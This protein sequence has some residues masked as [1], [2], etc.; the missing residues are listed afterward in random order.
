MLGLEFITSDIDLTSVLKAD[1][2]Y[3]T[4]GVSFFVAWVGA[5]AG[6]S[7]S[8]SIE[9][10]QSQ[11]SK[12][13]WLL[14]GSV[15]M[16]CAIWSM[17][18]VGMLAF[19]L[20]VPM[21]HDY[22]LTAI[23]IIPAILA[24]T[25]AIFALTM[26]HRSYLHVI[27]GGIIQGA[28]I[29]VMH[30]V[31][32]AACEGNFIMLYD[33]WIFALSIIV[34]VLLAI[35]SISASFLESKIGSYEGATNFFIAAPLMGGAITGMHYMGMLGVYFIELPT[36]KMPM[37]TIS[38][39]NMIIIIIA[40]T[41]ILSG[42]AIVSNTINK[43]FLQLTK[44]KHEAEKLADAKSEFLARM[45]HEIR[46]PMNAIIGMTRL[47]KRTSLT[48]RQEDYLTKIGAASNEL[49]G[50]INDIL[51]FSKIDAGKLKFENIDFSIETT[52]NNVVNVVGLRAEEKG[53][54]LVFNINPKVP[55]KLK[56]DP[57]RLGQILT[58]LIDNAVKFT[59]QGEITIVVNV[60]EYNQKQTTL[61]FKVIDTGIGLSESQIIGLFQSFV[62]ADSTVTRKYGGTGLGLAICKQLCEL[63]QGRIWVESTVG[64]GSTFNF[65]LPFDISTKIEPTKVMPEMLR[66]L[67]ILVIDDNENAL[68]V[69]T[70]LLIGFGLKT[71]GVNNGKDAIT[72]L[73]QAVAANTPYDIVLTDWRMPEMDGVEVTKLIRENPNIKHTPSILM[74]SAYGREELNCIAEDLGL[75]GYL[76]KPVGSSLL[77]D[78]I[79][80]LVI[81]NSELQ[82]AQK[83][84]AQVNQQHIELPNVTQNPH[85]I[86]IVEDNLFN[87]QIAIETLEFLGY[88]SDVANDGLEC[89]EFV[90]KNTYDLV[91]M[92]IQMPKMDGL[93]ATREIKKRWPEL[94]LPIIAM[95]AHAL[96]G[97]KD[98]SLAAGMVQHI[99]KPFNDDEL[100]AALKYWIVDR[101]ASPTD[102]AIRTSEVVA[103]SFGLSSEHS[104][105]LAS[106]LNRAVLYKSCKDDEKRMIKLL[107]I[108]LDS[109]SPANRSVIQLLSENK[110][111][112]AEMLAHSIKPAVV[113]LG[114]ELLSS[115]AS[116]IETSLKN[117]T[118]AIITH[119]VEFKVN[120]EQ[121]NYQ[122]DHLV[123]EVDLILTELTA[124]NGI[125]NDRQANGDKAINLLTQLIPMLEDDDFN[126]EQLAENL[127][128]QIGDKVNDP[129]IQ[130]FINAINDAEYEQA[131]KDVNK[132]KSV[133]KELL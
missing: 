46:T 133:I 59:Q 5:Y 48:L 21:H 2:N 86:L 32:M 78:S 17:H 9:A 62:Q 64:V 92:D 36:T 130:N 126:S 131:L 38:H 108:F 128:E 132:V 23:S 77:Y 4:V 51:D 45:S 60:K 93:T 74:V 113:F 114:D 57:I 98:K 40:T 81:E 8:T 116:K 106:G 12:I 63:M 55:L 83:A 54:E 33:P 28:G 117:N 56:G 37:N 11:R 110:I 112:E 1:Y 123:A 27:Y 122:L 72:I 22:L 84:Q 24:S 120:L 80:S 129:I 105:E 68:E 103:E 13:C 67:K 91:L 14:A 50:I 115:L 3:W 18:F 79:I 118:Q 95:T 69:L 44:S 7:V 35:L 6:I 70:E 42:L 58:N 65:E 104:P 47:A 34:A 96:K 109:F 87:Q 10:A 90:E 15:A 61:H 16:G 52:L 94:K 76:I 125:G 99:T 53:I 119:D 121:F 20:V 88:Q 29:G 49:L 100:N 111:L 19:E 97:D 26:R 43:I 82:T 107:K 101:K 25:A 73:E 85:K 102:D 71:K 30:Y 41:I 124:K 31:G 89:L 39:S 127:L 75:D 66:S